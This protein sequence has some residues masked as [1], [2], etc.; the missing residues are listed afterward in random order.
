M[1]PGKTPSNNALHD[2]VI[3]GVRGTCAD[4]EVKFPLRSEVQINRRKELLLLISKRIESGKRPVGRI[5][6][7][8]AIFLVKS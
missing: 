8:P 7:Q 5:V 2:Q 6:F 3:G 4:A 1:R